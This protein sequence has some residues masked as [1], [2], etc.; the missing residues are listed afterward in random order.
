MT[1]LQ[2]PPDET[3]KQKVENMT[4]TS[5]NLGGRPRG[6]TGN[7]KSAKER[8]ARA[9][10]EFEV[11]EHKAEL[12]A[13]RVEVSLLQATT[14]RKSEQAKRVHEKYVVQEERRAP[15][16]QIDQRGTLILLASLAGIMFITTAVLTADGTIGSAAAA[17]YAFPW[18]GFLLFGAIEVAVLVFLLVYYVRGSRINY[19]GTPVKAAQWFVAM[20][21]ASIVAVGASVYHVIDLYAYDWASIDMWVGIGL[22]LTTTVFFVLVAKAVATVLFAKAV[23]L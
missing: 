16:F 9:K 12:D 10:R 13:K 18:F 22:R 19:D 7:G 2:Y 21:V 4:I 17:R 11:E 14:S 1:L 23:R 8:I 15:Q 5:P 20:I 3:P 6:T